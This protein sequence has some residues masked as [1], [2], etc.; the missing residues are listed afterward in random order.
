MSRSAV[1][2]HVELVAHAVGHREEPV[3]ADAEVGEDLGL[4]PGQVGD[5]VGAVEA[6]L[7]PLPLVGTGRAEVVGQPARPD[8]E[9][10]RPVRRHPARAQGGRGRTL[11]L[12]QREH[13]VAPP[14][15][16]C[17]AE[18]LLDREPGPVLHHVA[19][20]APPRVGGAR[21]PR[22]RPAE[23]VGQRVDAVGQGR[24]HLAAGVALAP[25][26]EVVLGE[27][28]RAGHRPPRIIDI[29]VARDL[30][31]TEVAPG[32]PPGGVGD[33]VGAGRRGERRLQPAPRPPLVGVGQLPLD[34]P[35]APRLRRRRPAARVDDRGGAEG[36]DRHAAL[37]E[38]ALEVDLLG[39]HEEAL[40]E[41]A[42]RA[43]VRRRDPHRGADHPVDLGLRCRGRARR[44]RRR[45][46]RQGCRGSG[47][48]G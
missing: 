5:Q 33:E 23:L 39:V 28:Q 21:R 17:P 24:G 4:V 42:D 26:V 11:P 48:A 3:L 45:G 25:G 14:G 7:E 41:A 12:E 1:A 29:S 22:E 13:D 44:G 38:P 34:E 27:D 37:A 8:H 47:R 9:R 40:V 46:A 35:A 32:C 6:P 15:R 43:E 19:Q 18:R 31:R 2:G 30:Q 16:T 10:R 36:D 20:P